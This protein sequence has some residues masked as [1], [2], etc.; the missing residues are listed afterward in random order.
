L[1]MREMAMVKCSGLTVPSIKE[2][3]RLVSSTATEK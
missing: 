3:G 2:N 1:T